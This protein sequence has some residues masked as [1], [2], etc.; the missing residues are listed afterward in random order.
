MTTAK[1]LAAGMM[2]ALSLTFAAAPALAAEPSLL[3]VAQVNLVKGALYY[4]Q[5]VN[6]WFEDLAGLLRQRLQTA[7]VAVSTPKGI[8][9]AC[10]T[11]SQCK[12]GLACLNA[13][14]D[15][16]SDCLV[17]VKRC[18][19]P[20]NELRTIGQNGPCT[21]SDFCAEGTNCTRVCPSGIKC[22][23]ERLCLPTA[24]PAGAC[25]QDADCRANCAS[26]PLPTIG[27]AAFAPACENNICLCRVILVNSS[28]PRIVC[29]PA[30]AA[31]TLICPN[32]TTPGCTQEGCATD[33]CPAPRLT[34]LKAPEFGGKCFDDDECAKAA[35]PTGASPFCSEGA[36][37]CHSAKIET[38]SCQADAD[39]AAITCEASQ[40]KA[41][42][43]GE[44]AC[45]IK[46][47]VVTDSCSTAADCIGD[48]PSNYGLACVDGRCACQRTVEAAPKA[49]TILVDCVAVSCP[50]G[51]DKACL[52]G[53][54]A[55]TRTTTQ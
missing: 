25:A 5:T 40:V 8:G 35:C 12:A 26:R 55:C 46:T 50:D 43:S 36:C 7:T 28:L 32:G 21:N 48:C 17:A 4:V 30:L 33:P 51:Y 11:Q 13:C 27:E 34:C 41:C 38:V 47:Q 29:P 9:T 20:P 42:V 22:A 44:C 52:N 15:G 45:G 19:A 53:V 14:P 39:C 1:R 24:S 18:A 54:C 49:C 3:A 10:E 16:G 2:I 31:Q 6:N 23:N 37:K